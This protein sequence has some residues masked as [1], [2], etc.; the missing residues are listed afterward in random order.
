VFLFFGGVGG[1]LA[2][3]FLFAGPAALSLALILGT[4]T[5]WPLQAVTPIV[6][7][8]FLAGLIVQ[9]VVV[10]VLYVIAAIAT[11]PVQGRV[12]TNFVEGLCRGAQIGINACANLLYA[13]ALYPAI[14]FFAG[15]PAAI[16]VAAVL[17]P[18]IAAVL[19]LVNFLCVFPGLTNNF[20]FE[21]VLGWT[22]WFM[23][24]S[25][26]F[27]VLGFAAYLIGL[28][29]SWF[30]RPFGALGDWWP[31]AVARH[32]WL[33]D[34]GS[35]AFTIGNF[36]IVSGSMGRS[37]PEI[38][39]S[40][41]GP[42]AGFLTALGVVSHETGHTLTVAAFGFLMNAIGWLH[43][44]IVDIF[45]GSGGRAY[46]EF[47]CEGIR[48]MSGDPQFPDDNPWIAMWAPPLALAGPGGGNGRIAFAATVDGDAVVPSLS[49]NAAVNGPIALDASASADPDNY[50]MGTISPGGTPTL[51][52]RWEVTTRPP[53]SNAAIPNATHAVTTFTA[54]VPGSY[55]IAIAVCDGAEGE[56]HVVDVSV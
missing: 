32:G 37:S 5:I 16:A 15:G 51:G 38:V 26:P 13:A 55:Q 34:F 25:W 29:A 52:F 22:S 31:G 47:L 8:P 36:T 14:A 30:G 17:T 11:P 56:L 21:A 45:T 18:I 53:G 35:S 50:P 28:V 7:L 43:E 48:R 10:L 9:L 6:T 44:R 49:V 4:A 33:F 41:S 24:M 40:A 46:F 2:A 1:F 20:A 39:A 23:P 27:Q 54:D 19:G 42:Q 3:L 12:A